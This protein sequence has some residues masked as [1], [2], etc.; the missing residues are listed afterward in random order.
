MLKS[1]FDGEKLLISN[2]RTLG[3]ELVGTNYFL[4]K[5]GPSVQKP[6]H[7]GK[8]SAGWLFDFETQN[9]KYEEPVV[10]WNTWEQVRDTLKR[11]TVDS[12]DYVIM[13]EYD[14]VVPYEDF[15]LIVETKQKDDWCTRNPDNFKYSR[16]VNGYRFTDEEFW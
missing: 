10:V 8:S 5:N 1:F 4:V 2:R 3:G 12:T 11:L 16:N 9:R 7:I 14:G 15:V 13:D 6:I